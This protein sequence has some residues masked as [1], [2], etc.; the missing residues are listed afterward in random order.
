M[1]QTQSTANQLNTA[2]SVDKVCDSSAL[3]FHLQQHS[4]YCREYIV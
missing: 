4:F 1:I 2:R 3:P